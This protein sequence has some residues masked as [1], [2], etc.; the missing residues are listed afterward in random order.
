MKICSTLV[1]CLLCFGASFN[2]VLAQIWCLTSLLAGEIVEVVGFGKEL[3]A[4]M[5]I[6]MTIGSVDSTAFLVAEIQGKIPNSTTNFGHTEE[7]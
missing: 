3:G 5:F 7:P 1:L 6:Y 2:G 4:P